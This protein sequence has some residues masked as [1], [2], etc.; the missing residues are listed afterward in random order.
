[1]YT[2]S[3]S[4]LYVDGEIGDDG[5][6]TSFILRA[7][8]GLEQ[9]LA[10]SAPSMLGATYR[11]ESREWVAPVGV[12]REIAGLI[13]ETHAVVLPK[14]SEAFGVTPTD[15]VTGE[16]VPEP[17]WG[18]GPYDVLADSIDD[19]TERVIAAADGRCDE[20]GRIDDLSIDICLEYHDD[21]HVARYR[22]I[23]TRCSGC[24]YVAHHGQ[25]RRTY[26]DLDALMHAGAVNG[27]DET[28]T[29]RRWK[30]DTRTWR[31]RSDEDWILDLGGL[32]TDWGIAVPV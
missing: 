2:T 3:K 21:T 1:M 22:E 25:A 16:L 28:E 18:K 32:D 20:C 5:T 10:R 27:W 11:E 7:R 13:N 26:R 6:V 12:R 30:A 9:L 29:L 8:H 15:R 31:D 19:L 24:R 14:A 4:Q 17:L 23:R